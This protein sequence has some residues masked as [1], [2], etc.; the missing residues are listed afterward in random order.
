ME[1]GELFGV[2]LDISHDGRYFLAGAYFHSSSVP[3]AGRVELIDTDLEQSV[4]VLGLSEN[5]AFGFSVSMSGDAD[6]NG[7][8]RTSDGIL[9]V[10]DRDFN[11]EQ[12]INPRLVSFTTVF[13]ISG[14]G[15]WLVIAGDEMLGNSGIT[16]KAKV[17]RFDEASNK[18][19]P[20]GGDIEIET[21]DDFGNYNVDISDDGSV[22]VVTTI[23]DMME[24]DQVGSFW[25]YERD[26]PS[27]GYVQLGDRM[28]SGSEDDGF[29]Q[30]V[31][32]AVTDQSEMIVAVGIPADGK[33][34]VYMFEQDNDAWIVYSEINAGEEYNSNAEFGY[35]LSLSK[36]AGRLLVG[37]R[38][39]VGLSTDGC[40]GAAQAFDFVNGTAMP[41]GSI[42]GGPEYSF[43]GEAV[44]LSA[45]GNTFI[46]GAPE[47]CTELD[48]P[49]SVY[50]FEA[51]IVAS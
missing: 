41:V 8:I 25:A 32:I 48:C 40:D 20:F 19:V 33:V 24:F 7:A 3:I 23:G 26:P 10:L 47:D 5:D 22:F 6:T 43:F 34:V 13:K 45:D 1:D 17:Y 27:T 38:C 21:V 11:I 51:E 37:A 30:A 42:L 39:F 15:N 9:E 28:V 49:G 16:L 2:S 44:A 31:E 35:S 46:V 29:G 14:D 12:E 50:L 36:N 18:F 4:D